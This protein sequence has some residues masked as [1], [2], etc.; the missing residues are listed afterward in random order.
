MNPD[1]LFQVLFNLCMNAMQAQPDGGKVSVRIRD[2]LSQLSGESCVAIE[3][4]DE[5]P[6]VPTELLGKITS[7]F[8]TTKAPGEGSG[9]GLAIVD[10]LVR[11]AGGRLEVENREEKGARFR[12]VLPK[13]E[14]P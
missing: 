4:E 5:G 11:D 14:M 9:L 2:E 13:V 8:F 7:P 10:G 12:V 6:G 1:R 3:V